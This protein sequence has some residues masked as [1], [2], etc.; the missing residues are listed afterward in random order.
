MFKWIQT[1]GLAEYGSAALVFVTAAVIGHQAAVG[2]TQSQ[3][4]AA[5]VSI[6]GSISVAVMV[7]MW[8]DKSKAVANKTQQD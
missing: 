1:A 7:H 8:P 6:L 5:A 4:L 3:W 2:M